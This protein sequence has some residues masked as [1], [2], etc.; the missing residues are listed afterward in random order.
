KFFMKFWIKKLKNNHFYKKI[1]QKYS[2]KCY[3]SLL[4]FFRNLINKAK[5][6]TIYKIY[7]NFERTKL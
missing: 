5:K 3:N 7:E 1:K 4:K 2:K 6:D